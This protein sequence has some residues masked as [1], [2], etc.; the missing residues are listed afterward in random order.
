MV[1]QN[2]IEFHKQ[3]VDF[4][5]GDVVEG[6]FKSIHNLNENKLNTLQKNGDQT[7]EQIENEYNDDLNDR[8]KEVNI[9]DL[10]DKKYKKSLR[11]SIET[12]LRAITNK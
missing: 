9:K 11:G 1:L 8:D 2:A 6:K 3:M 12:P 7:F 4:K 10:K 5:I